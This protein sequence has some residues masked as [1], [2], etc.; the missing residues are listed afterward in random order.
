MKLRT[1]TL[2]LCSALAFMVAANAVEYSGLVGAGYHHMTD[3]DITAGGG[4]ALFSFG[5]PGFQAQLDASNEHYAEKG[6]TGDLT[7]VTGDFF[8]R[9]AKGSIGASL[10]YHRISA[11]AY[12]YYYGGSEDVV[13]YG[14]FGEWYFNRWLSLRVKGGGYSG[15][16]SGEYAGAGFRLYP[17]PNLALNASYDYLSLNGPYGSGGNA[18]QIGTYAEYMP[19]RSMPVSIAASYS[20]SKFSGGDSANTF[21]VVLI[22]RFGN[23]RDH[24]L[25]GWDRNGPIQWNGAL[26]L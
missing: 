11:G 26:P 5:N 13:S 7:T 8:W 22:Y 23:P 14:A 12:G 16:L 1:A 25:S 24:S 2:C 10:S 19:M 9:D 21:G 15:D 20:Y 3:T 17:L 6:V 4:A 18:D